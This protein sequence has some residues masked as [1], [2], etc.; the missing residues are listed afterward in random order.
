MRRVWPITLATILAGPALVRAQEL[1]LV[2]VSDLAADPDCSTEGL[3]PRVAAALGRPLHD[4]PTRLHARVTMRPLGRGARGERV[5]VVVGLE[6]DGVRSERAFDAPDCAAAVRA[7]ALVIALA[8]SPDYDAPAADSAP[9]AADSPPGSARGQPEPVGPAPAPAAAPLR[10]ERRSPPARGEPADPLVALVSLGGG[11][12]VVGASSEPR[13]VVRVG[14]GLA[15]APLTLEADFA[16]VASA[17]TTGPQPGAYVD[18]SLAFGAIRAGAL[19]EVTGPLALGAAVELDVGAVT[20]RGGGARV[21][22]R[23]TATLPWVA[24]RVGML[25]EVA[26]VGRLAIRATGSVGTPLVAPRFTI[27][28]AGAF[29]A[30]ST[31]LAEGGLGLVLR[32]G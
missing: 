16:Y 15:L 31:V 25:A 14:G 4:G 17:R 1:D 22:D 20:G 2:A 28:G 26:L 27:D 32:L 7:A 6:R 30:Q 3:A 12:I 24:L 10:P 9:L 18:R 5:H 19:V 13:T 11:A 8:L 23:S 29:R 21:Q